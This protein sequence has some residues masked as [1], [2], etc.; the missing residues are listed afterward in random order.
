MLFSIIVFCLLGGILSVV[1]ASSFLLLSDDARTRALPH[2]VSFAT[3]ALLGAAFLGLLPHAMESPT[4]QDGHTVTFAVLLGILGFFLLE[5]MVLWRHCHTDHCE[6]HGPEEVHQHFAPAGTLV[7]VGDSIHNLVDGVLIGA[8]FLTDFHLGVVTT[9]AVAAHEIPQEVG[10]F[11]ILLHSGFSRAKA[12]VFNIL[13]S[14]TTVVGGVIAFYG[15]KEFEPAL[16]YV[17]AVAAA[18]FIYV[19]VA[20]LIPTLHKRT[21]LVATLQQMLLIGAGVTVIFLAHNSMH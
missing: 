12:L 1:L 20:D 11:I 9:L 6:A 14:L 19:A 13:S 10:D 8:A 4:V 18:S 21:H 3:G 17:L 2:L 15:L 16:P 7:L 5:K